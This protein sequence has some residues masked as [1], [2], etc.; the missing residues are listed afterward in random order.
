MKI[1]CACQSG[2]GSSFLVEMNVKQACTNLGVEA[3][4]VHGALYECAI[5]TADLFITS[6]DLVDEVKK[7]GDT[8]GVKDLMS[9]EEIQN[10]LK[11][12]FDNKK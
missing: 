11:E 7:F 10:K 9:V 3:I 12:Y 8:V 5:G 6:S 1:M 2:L 4:V